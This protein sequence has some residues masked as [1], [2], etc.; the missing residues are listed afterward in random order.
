MTVL[1]TGQPAEKT[2]YI[3]NLAVEGRVP[4]APGA[5]ASSIF[6]H[7]HHLRC[8][9]REPAPRQTRSRLHSHGVPE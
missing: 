1:T 3:D 2:R 5:R 7:G 6:P 8:V 4:V 9:S